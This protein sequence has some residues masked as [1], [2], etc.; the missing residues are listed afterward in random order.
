MRVLRINSIVFLLLASSLVFGFQT[1]R[2]TRNDIEYE[3]E[4]PSSAWRVISRLDV[5]DH[6]EFI[7]GT[8][9]QSREIFNTEITEIRRDRRR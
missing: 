1:Q 6:L 5:H 2:F 8:D 4:L 3:L 7:N 9:P